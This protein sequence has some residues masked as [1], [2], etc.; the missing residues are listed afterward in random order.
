MEGGGGGMGGGAKICRVGTVKGG[1]RGAGKAFPRNFLIFFNFF[2]KRFFSPP[3]LE[4]SGQR[5]ARQYHTT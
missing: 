1:W 2:V 5:S 3:M 4:K